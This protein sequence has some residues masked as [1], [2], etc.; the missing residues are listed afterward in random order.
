MRSINITGKHNIDKIKKLTDGT[1]KSVRKSMVKIDETMLKHCKQ[2]DIIKQFYSINED[3]L[4]KSLL[5]TEL[6]NKIQGYKGQDIRKNINNIDTLIT[7]EDVV[8]KLVSNQLR[9]CYCS[10]EIYVF[11]KNVRDPSQWTL[12]RINNDLSHTKDNTCIACL[13]CNLQRRVIDA[14]KFMFTKKMVI[15]KENE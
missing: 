9:C 6:K 2:L 12:D 15:V 13:R 10:K 7:L 3:F 8:E 11:Y 1:F 4:N 14:D 5:E